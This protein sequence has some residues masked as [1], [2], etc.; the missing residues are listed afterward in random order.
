MWEE[1]VGGYGRVCGRGVWEGSVR[2][3]CRRVYEETYERKRGWG[4]EWESVEEE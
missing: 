1:S 3:K 2:E 4:C